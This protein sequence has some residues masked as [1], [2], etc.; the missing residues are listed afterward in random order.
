MA[1][2]CHKVQE[3]YQASLYMKKYTRFENGGD[4]GRY[5]M[6]HLSREDIK[7]DQSKNNSFSTIIAEWNAFKLSGTKVL[8]SGGNGE[9]WH[10]AA[11]PTAATDYGY[12]GVIDGVTDGKGIISASKELGL[13][14]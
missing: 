8:P 13:P 1:I 6:R 9:L 2:Y 10:T 12:L 7:I 11:T 5:Q 14:S 4:I 3:Q